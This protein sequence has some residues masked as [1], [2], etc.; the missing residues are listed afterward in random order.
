MSQVTKIDFLTACYLNNIKVCICYRGKCG[1]CVCNEI[2]NKIQS[3]L[4]CNGS[5]GKLLMRR[6]SENKKKVLFQVHY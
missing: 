2:E 5:D 1:L 4:S 3:S 6:K